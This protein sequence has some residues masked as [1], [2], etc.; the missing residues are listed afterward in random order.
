MF[1]FEKYMMTKPDTP[2]ITINDSDSS[3]MMILYLV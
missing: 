1:N 3:A 2:T